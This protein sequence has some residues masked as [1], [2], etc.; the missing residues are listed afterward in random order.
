MRKHVPKRLRSIIFRLCWWANVF[1][2]LSLPP[3]SQAA[4]AC[5]RLLPGTAVRDC[6]EATLLELCLTI[7]V[8]FKHTWHLPSNAF[9][10]LKGVRSKAAWSLLET[11][12]SVFC[13]GFGDAGVWE[14]NSLIVWFFFSLKTK[15]SKLNPFMLTG[16]SF[17][18]VI[19][20]WNLW[21]LP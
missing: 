14:G 5:H 11:N 1:N 2:N 9:R 3:R 20:S 10:P 19:F 16:L 13:L 12:I 21:S 18:T 15:H 8:S 17:P 4:G 6:G 7:P